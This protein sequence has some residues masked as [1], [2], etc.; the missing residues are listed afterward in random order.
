MITQATIQ[1]L[2]DRMQRQ[3]PG[4]EAQ[5]RM[6]H[7]VRRADAP[8]PDHA[9][10]AG[11]LAMF[12]PNIRD[13]WNLAL[14]ERVTLHSNDRHGGQISFPGGGYEEKD[15]TLLQTA[16]RETREE[17]GVDTS[18]VE[19]LGPLT[20]LYIPVSNY[21]VHP[22]VGILP[23]TPV[24]SPQ[25]DEVAAVVE[26]PLGDFLNPSSRQMTD[27][28]LSQHIVLKDVPYFNI[29]GKVI[30]GATAMMLNELLTL[31]ED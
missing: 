20:E 29:A 6:A 11:V 12:Y 10:K 15:Q 3:L 13:E 8:V 4:K 17:I 7:A 22:F 21:L 2:Q 19:V 5:Y 18:Q 1:K 30:W 31:L 27:L 25:W 16:L 23:F 14:I 24:F 9:R 26:A 28:R